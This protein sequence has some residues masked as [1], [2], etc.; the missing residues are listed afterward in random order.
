MPL[1]QY[2][3]VPVVLLSKIGDVLIDAVDEVT[4]SWESQITKHPTETGAAP[5]DHIINWPVKITMGGRFTDTP[6]AAGGAASFNPAAALTSALQSGLTGGL[7]VQKWQALEALRQRKAVFAVNVQQGTYESMAFARLSAPRSKGDG[8]SMRF[9][10]ELEQII[11]TELLAI[12]T[13]PAAVAADVAHTA[14]GT[15]DLG[16]QATTPWVT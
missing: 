4:V 13:N 8:R 1:Y 10:A 11:T 9:T 6:L 5:S 12:L 7:S 2:F 16:A 14:T 15:P 3:G